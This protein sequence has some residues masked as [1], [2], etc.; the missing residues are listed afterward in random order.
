MPEESKVDL[1]SSSVGGSANYQVQHGRVPTH[2][3]LTQESDLALKNGVSRVKV[4]TSGPNS[5]VDKVLSD[6]RSINW[7]LF[8]TEAF[9]FEF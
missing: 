6:S 3:I 5:L 4:L 1:E 7:K 9:S 8:D 2:A